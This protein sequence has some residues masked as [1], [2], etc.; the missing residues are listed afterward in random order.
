M[1][2]L[3]LTIEH[4]E[5][6]KEF[7]P[8]IG[9][10][11]PRFDLFAE[12]ASHRVIV[13]IQHARTTDHYD[14]FL[15]YHCIALL[16]QIA[17]AENYRP[18]LKVFTIVVL[19]SGDRHKTDISVTDFD[20][21]NL[22]GH[23][24][25]EI[26]H[27]IE[28]VASFFSVIHKPSKRMDKQIPMKS[29]EKNIKDQ[30]HE[31]WLNER[32]EIDQRI[33]QMV[34]AQKMGFLGLKPDQQSAKFVFPGK[35]AFHRKPQGIHGLIPQAR[36]TAFGRLRLAIARILL[37]VRPESP[38]ENF[39]AIGATIN[40]GIQIDRNPSHRDSHDPNDA[41]YLIQ[42]I[43]Q[44]RNIWGLRR[45]DGHGAQYVSRVINDA[46][47][48][49]PRE[50]FMPGIGDRLASFFGHGIRAVSMNWLQVFC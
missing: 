4:V 7:D 25:H 34:E 2:G 9:Y 6:E 24:L 5:T 45:F 27:K 48:F 44:Q 32:P 13:D 17:N 22:Q 46:Q 47:R 37:D 39:L 28:L 31:L 21:H 29:I 36:T 33:G 38:L 20:P 26:P 12:D 30:E 35:R 42:R 19:T 3:S 1:I 18:S 15:Y 41:P 10:V 14:R 50:S 40:A 11:T 43:R 23:P 8:P 16:E 49:T